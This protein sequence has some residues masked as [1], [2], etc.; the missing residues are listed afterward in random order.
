M[1]RFRNGDCSDIRMQ[2]GPLGNNLLFQRSEIIGHKSD[3][4]IVDKNRV[5][6]FIRALAKE[7]GLKVTIR[8]A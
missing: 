3:Y 8:K 7:A 6:N 2:Q 4:I 5:L 1:T